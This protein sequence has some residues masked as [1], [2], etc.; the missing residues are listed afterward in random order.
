MLYDYL[1][2]GIGVI[3]L[4]L[5][6]GVSMIGRLN[7]SGENHRPF[8]FPSSAGLEKNHAKVVSVSAF[9]VNTVLIALLVRNFNHLI[10]YANLGVLEM[11]QVELAGFPTGKWAESEILPDLET[12]ENSLRSAL[13]FDPLNRTANHRLGLIAM[14]RRD[15]DSAVE[16]LEV[17]HNQTPEHRGIIK[18]L[19]YCYVWLG[20]IDRA[21]MFLSEIPEAEHELGVYDWW[22]SDRGRDDLS[23]NAALMGSH[24]ESATSQP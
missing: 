7:A 18:S 24:L 15:F 3:L 8:R 11:A 6:V 2:N 5:P 13:Q 14:L 17:A 21:Q 20:D 19:G 10:W 12:A 1:Y 23:A 4:L 9:A 16:Y 22:W